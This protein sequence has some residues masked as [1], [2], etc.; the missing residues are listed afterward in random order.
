MRPKQQ[1]LDEATRFLKQYFDSQ[2]G[3]VD[4]EYEA[5]LDEVTRSIEATGTYDVSYEELVFGAQ[6]A[7]RNSARCI[8]M[9]DFTCGCSP[10]QQAS[11]YFFQNHERLD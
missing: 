9:H 6:T 1:L 3:D 11:M 8:G 2:S 7:W 10:V 5:R 4:D